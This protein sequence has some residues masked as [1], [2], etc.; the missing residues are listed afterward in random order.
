MVISKSLFLSINNQDQFAFK[1]PC[2]IQEL[3][4]WDNITIKFK[5]DSSL[6]Y[7]VYTKDNALHGIRMLYHFLQ[8]ALAGKKELPSELKNQN[9]GYLWEEILADK[10]TDYPHTMIE[11]TPVWIGQRYLLWSVAQTCI[12]TWFYSTDGELFFE[13]SPGYIWMFREPEPQSE[14]FITYEEFIKNYQPLVI[15]HVDRQRA[16]SWLP[17]LEEILICMEK[18]SLPPEKRGKTW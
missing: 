9:L 3:E 5:R 14:D 4:F 16:E 2:I 18:N 10:I 12:N 11:N 7:I 15:S 6:E 17:Q 1:L 13:I 8:K